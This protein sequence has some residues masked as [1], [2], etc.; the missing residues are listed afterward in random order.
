MLCAGTKTR[1]QQ[2]TS[3]QSEHLRLPAIVK[4]DITNVIFIYFKVT[5]VVPNGTCFEES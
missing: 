5:A 3:G 1:Q 4:V 2:V